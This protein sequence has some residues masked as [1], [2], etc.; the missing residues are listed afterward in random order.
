[1]STPQNPDWNRFLAP[2]PAA[3]DYR[4]RQRHA[5]ESILVTGAGGSI[6]SALV[7]A[8]ASAKPSRI[9]LLESSEQALFEVLQQ[10]KAAFPGVAHEAVL[11]SCGD[12]A[13]LDSI[14]ENFQ[15]AIIYH[16]AAFKHVPLL[17][18]NPFAAVRNNAIGTYALAQAA[19]RHRLPKVVLVST[20]KAANPV[21]VLGV[22][23]RISELVV[24]SLSS[25]CTRMNAV[26]LGNVIG[27]SGSVV[28]IF[29]RQIAAGGPVTV[30]HLNATRRFMSLPEAVDAILATGASHCEGRILL[31]PMGDPVCIAD[32]ARFLIDACA[33]EHG[34]EIPIRFTGL[35]PG[36][37]LAE[38]LL[39]ASEV[40]EGKI[41]GRLEVIRTPARS[42][43]EL[44]A[45]MA[46]LAE[47]ERNRDLSGLFDA[48]CSAVP[49]YRAAKLRAVC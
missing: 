43:E 22:T 47:C 39:L 1:M 7:L 3:V 33:P 45:I 46:Q 18:G 48:M 29:L 17:E 23:K 25:S 15:P 12:R 27:S 20:D 28:P 36:E 40:N 31:P 42:P 14:L 37:K 44:A 32:L 6:G 26:R 38:D 19:A 10:L 4:F 30:T 41:D 8:I 49:E 9:L 11:G 24:V 2:A 13:L 34:Q 21:S 16:A 5:G 35:R